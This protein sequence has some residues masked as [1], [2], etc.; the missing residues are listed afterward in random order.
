MEINSLLEWTLLG[1]CKVSADVNNLLTDSEEAIA[2]YKTFR[3]TAIFTNKRIIMRDAQGITGK[4]AE[5]YSIPY[6]SI[7]IWSTENAGM[8]DINSE[9]CLWTR[10]GN[11]KIKL[12]KGVDVRAFDKLI[13]N[14]VLR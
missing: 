13:A 14:Y 2:A 5:V 4:K 10:L 7:L 11:F 6:D 8:L 1:E 3:D 12:S 9:V